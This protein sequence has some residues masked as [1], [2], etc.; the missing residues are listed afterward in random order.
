MSQEA[1]NRDGNT[2]IQIWLR[3]CSLFSAGLGLGFIPALV[4]VFAFVLNVVPGLTKAFGL[5]NLFVLLGWIYGAEW[6]IDLAYFIPRPVRFRWLSYGMTS[7]L[8]AT[9]FLLLELYSHSNV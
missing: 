1:S 2:T 8:L 6:I 4:F 7:A 9:A 5:S 3:R